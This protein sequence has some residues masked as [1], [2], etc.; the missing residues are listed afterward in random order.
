MSTGLASAYNVHFVMTM[1]GSF[2]IIA[3]IIVLIYLIPPV[4]LA[5]S[6]AISLMFCVLSEVRFLLL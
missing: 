4:R 6:V 1:P 3:E 2:F 5:Y